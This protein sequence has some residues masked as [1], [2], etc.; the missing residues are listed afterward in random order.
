MSDVAAIRAGK[1]AVEI[2]GDDKKLK[3]ANRAF[4]GLPQGLRQ[5]GGGSQRR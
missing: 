4:Q 2:S 5:S 3:E 1:A